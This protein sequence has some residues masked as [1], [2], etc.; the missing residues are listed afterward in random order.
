[1]QLRRHPQSSRPGQHTPSAYFG[2]KH[3]TTAD[4]LHHGSACLLQLQIMHHYWTNLHIN[5]NSHVHEQQFSGNYQFEKNH[6]II[7]SGLKLIHSNFQ[8]LLMTLDTQTIYQCST[9]HFSAHF[10]C[11]TE[12]YGT[13][14]KR[15]D[16]III[17]EKKATVTFCLLLWK[18]VLKR[19]FCSFLAASLLAALFKIYFFAFF[20]SLVVHQA[21]VQLNSQCGGAASVAFSFQLP[22]RRK[23]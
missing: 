2:P 5:V 20:G 9:S 22:F 11:F 14:E 3:N 8:T 10:P 19:V 18:Q 17:I 15:N 7:C 4:F 1:M 16:S 21:A 13:V 6:K 23:L 12:D